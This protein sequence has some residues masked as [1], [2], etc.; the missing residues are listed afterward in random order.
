VYAGRAGGPGLTDSLARQAAADPAP[1][2]IYPGVFRLLNRELSDGCHANT[3]GQQSLGR[4]AIAF[5]AIAF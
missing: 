2:V 5:C 3:A 1:N 4:Q